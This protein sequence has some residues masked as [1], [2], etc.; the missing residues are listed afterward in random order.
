[1]EIEGKQIFEE[2][3]SKP[4]VAVPVKTNVE[5]ATRVFLEVAA[6]DDAARPAPM[7]K[8]YL[9]WV[10]EELKIRCQPTQ[11]N[12]KLLLQ[13]LKDAMN[14]NLFQYSTLEKAKVNSKSK[15]KKKVGDVGGMKHVFVKQFPSTAYWKAL[16]PETDIVSEP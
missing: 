16:Q 13:I 8:Q 2:E 11:G 9:D 4:P 14:R 7:A 12:K 10:K 3:E 15:K 1:M 6:A 5:S